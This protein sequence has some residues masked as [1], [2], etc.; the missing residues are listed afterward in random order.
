MNGQYPATR[1]SMRPERPVVPA[2]GSAAGGDCEVD[3]LDLSM[4]R[5][6]RA[7]ARPARRKRCASAVAGRST[8]TTG[9]AAQ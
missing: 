7:V 4:L 5:P 3:G 8:S 2:P 1:Q 6:F 9:E